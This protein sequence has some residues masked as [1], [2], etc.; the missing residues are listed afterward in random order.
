[1]G[2]PPTLKDIMMKRL[3]LPLIICAA[4][5][6]TA[7]LETINKDLAIGA[8]VDIFKSATV[9][10]SEVI[11]LAKVSA[12]EL[13]SKNKVAGPENPY[14]KRLNKVFGKH[15][16][17]DGLTLN[18][19][20]YLSD[21][22]NAFAMPDGTIRVYSGLMDE[23]SDEELLAVIGHEIGHVK[24]EHSLRSYRS[25]Y[26][27]SGIRK[28]AASL[29]GTGGELVASQ[30]GAIGQQFVSSQFSQAHEL[31]ADQ[32][33]MDLMK[34]HGY[35]PRAMITAFQKMKK[36]AGEGGGIMS[37]HPSTSKRIEKMESQL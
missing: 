36:V 22:F 2:L 4:L 33:G 18:Y 32:Y 5:L 30:L 35:N 9:S 12:K 28:G 16:N 37:S 10:D 11:G 3:Y 14:T 24:K 29:G 17:E 21:T 13:D 8:G 15:K 27:S 19:K 23:L 25:A 7:C 20:V 6:T 1:M 31:E 26:L 34:K